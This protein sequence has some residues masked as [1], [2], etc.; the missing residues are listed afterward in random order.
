MGAV[1]FDVIFSTEPKN[2]RFKAVSDAIGETIQ[3]TTEK[4]AERRTE[5]QTRLQREA[6]KRTQERNRYLQGIADYQDNIKRAGSGRAEILKG[7]QA[8]EDATM[9]LL[10]ACDVIAKMTGDET[11]YKT[12]EAS[13]LTAY[14][15]GAGETATI[16]RELNQ[17]QDRFRRLQAYAE[18]EADAINK[19]RLQHAIEQH[20]KYIISLEES[21]RE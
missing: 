7:I 11:Y 8:G 15:I 20:H 13:I 6:D 4:P 2:K 14:G 18:H 3:E 9:L 1:D 10:K 12:A 5:A 16:Q 19:R 21:L 17:A